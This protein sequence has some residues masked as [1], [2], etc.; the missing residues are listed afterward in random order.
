VV[1]RALPLLT[2]PQMLA[3]TKKVA[4][5]IYQPGQPILLRNQE[6][7]SFFMIASGEVEV[8]LEGKKGPGQVIARLKSGD[9]FGETS[10]LSGGRAI[11]SIHAVGDTPAVLLELPR[12]EFL[13][14]IRESPLTEEAISKIVQKRLAETG[15]VVPD[16]ADK[17]AKKKKKK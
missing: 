4:R 3:I 2:H 12:Q 14:M 8:V 17:V 15:A 7:R 6:V 5:K 9:F 10:L 1:A 13:R 16:K 11:A